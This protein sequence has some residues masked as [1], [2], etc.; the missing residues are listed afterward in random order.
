ML[1]KV[2]PQKIEQTENAIAK[3]QKLGI[4][5]SEVANMMNISLSYLWRIQKGEIQMNGKMI[6]SL[7]KSLSFLNDEIEELIQSFR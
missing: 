6:L 3:L 1:E 7:R 4:S 2:T 5:K